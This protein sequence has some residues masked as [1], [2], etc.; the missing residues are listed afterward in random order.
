MIFRVILC[1]SNRLRHFIPGS[2]KSVFFPL[3]LIHPNPNQMRTHF[4]EE[5]LANLAQSIT[6]HGV[7]EEFLRGEK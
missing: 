4:D 3:S 2:G 5:A 7:M 6:A 1:D